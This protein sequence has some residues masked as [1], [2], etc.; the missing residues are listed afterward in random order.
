MPECTDQNRGPPYGTVGE[1]TGG[2]GSS[3]SVVPRTLILF[4]LALASPVVSP[5]RRTLLG[6]RLHDRADQVRAHPVARADAIMEHDPSRHDPPIERRLDPLRRL[7][8]DAGAEE[9]AGHHVEVSVL[10]LRV[11]REEA[12]HAVHIDS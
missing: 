7:A 5:V 2:P 10:V 8:C 4:L 3:R 9:H 11:F 12:R 6:G 1:T